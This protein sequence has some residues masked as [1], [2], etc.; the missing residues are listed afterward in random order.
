MAKVTLVVNG[1]AFGGW[2]SATVT[3][4]METLAGSFV[5]SVTDRWIGQ[6][7]PWPIR[8][9]DFC[10]IRLDDRPMLTGYIDTH[11]RSI[12][13]D[14]DEIEIT[15]RDLA[16][17][18]VD[19]SAVLKQWEFSNIG[20][21]ELCQ[22]VAEPFG[23]TVWLQDGITDKAISTTATKTG[24][25]RK[26]AHGG[27]SSVGAEGKS[28]SLTNAQPYVKF[29]IDPGD[30][31][32]GVIARACQLVGVLAVSDGVGGIL[33]TRA[34]SALMRTALVDGEGGNVLQ[35][36][37]RF[38]ATERYRRYIVSGQSARDESVGIFGTAAAAVRQEATDPNVRREDRVLL[39]RPGGA[40][41]AK[42]AR[43]YAAWLATVR[44]ARSGRYQV[45]VQGWQMA[46]GEYWP[47]NVRV[48][49]RIPRLSINGD[50]LITETA[51]SLTADGGSQTTITLVHPD[52]YVPEPIVP[53]TGGS[54]GA[55][56]FLGLS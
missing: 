25:P 45:T 3:R 56:G 8:V 10:E 52:A 34:S 41:T 48:P 15:G 20:V 33:L 22:K 39:V 19:N 2:K 35:A 37:A 32:H 44:T 53:A 51:F 24:K 21:L 23:I 7:Q 54:P 43:Q 50:M 46:N 31:P 27:P 14:A 1:K 17:A 26:L 29:T 13:G 40:I 28:S 36:S 47:F 55:L 5:L 38:D 9:E 16:G 30:S 49:V 18:L 4:G 42:F 11:D 6:Q 12:R